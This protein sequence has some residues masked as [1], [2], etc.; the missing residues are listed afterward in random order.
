VTVTS[1]S[2]Q[3]RAKFARDGYLILESSEWFDDKPDSIVSALE[4]LYGP[5][6]HEDGV[7]FAPRRIIDAWKINTDVK[8]LALDERILAVLEGLYGKRP[9]PFQTL[10]FRVGTEQAAHSD[11]LH[12]NSMPAGF[13]CGVWIALEDIDRENGPLVYYPGS[14]KLPEV[15]MKDVGLQAR[16]EDY[17]EYERYLEDLIRSEELEPEYATIDKG[18]ALIWASNLMHGGSPQEDKSRTRFSQVTHYFF[19]G[20]K[21]YTPMLTDDEKTWWRNPEWIR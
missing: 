15:T 3:Q 16:Q 19:E 1:V 9:L 14:H 20:C 18:Q 21:Y 6:R 10:N 17:P 7:V 5:T 8:A 13:M 12:F 2:E 11:T 4:G